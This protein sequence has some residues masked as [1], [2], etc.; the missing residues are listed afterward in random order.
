MKICFLTI[1]GQPE[2]NSAFSVNELASNDLAQAQQSWQQYLQ[3]AVTGSDTPEKEIN[4][5][6]SILDTE[7]LHKETCPD[8]MRQKLTVHLH[9]AGALAWHRL[10]E[11]YRSGETC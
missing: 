8:H 3:S 6:I 1:D 11:K 5:L 2:G 9:P 4:I 10:Q 7:Q